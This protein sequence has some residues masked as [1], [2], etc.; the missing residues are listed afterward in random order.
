MAGNE[1]SFFSMFRKFG[2]RKIFV[3]FDLWLALALAFL[4]AYFFLRPENAMLLLTLSSRIFLTIST[5]LVTV[6]LA[7][8]AIVTSLSD[9]LFASW[10]KA[11]KRPRN[12]NVYDNVL[13]A[14]WFV[15]FLGSISLSFS[16]FGY[17]CTVLVAN[18]TIIEVITV[19]IVFSALYTVFATIGLLWSIFKWGSYRAE[20]LRTAVK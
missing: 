2:I 3:S 11:V 12:S 4:L 10:A 20:Y 17:F 13:F 7:G 6:S 14:F 8:L 1:L 9:P 5:A 15:S 19:L 18:T 16:V